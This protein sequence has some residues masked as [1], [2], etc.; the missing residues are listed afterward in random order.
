MDAWMWIGLVA[1]VVAMAAVAFA[2]WYLM[3]QKKE[4][5]RS[6]VLR[7]QFGPEYD[8]AV[9]RFGTRSEAEAQ[10]EG[11]K[12]RVEKLRLK[13]IPTE[14]RQRLQREWKDTQARFVDEPEPAMA[15]AER[16]VDEAMA[17]RGYPVGDDFDQRYDDLS[18]EYGHVLNN[19]REG[20]EIMAARDDG[21]EVSTEDLRQ[22]MVHYRELFTEVVNTSDAPPSIDE[23]RRR[24]KG[25]S[26]RR[27]A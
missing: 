7:E 22:A 18:V 27:S 23:G 3:E 12:E 17:A 1:A 15:D 21:Q 16:L 5:E 2:A 25:Q 13:E 24:R 6:E 8:R 14:Q 11:R 26:T 4:Q 19:Y 20:R 9:G 10:L